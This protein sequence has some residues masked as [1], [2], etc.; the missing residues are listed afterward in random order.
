MRHRGLGRVW[1]AAGL[2]LLA[3]APAFAADG[4]ST[5]PKNEIVVFGGASILDATRR[6]DSTVGIPGW[7]AGP[8]SRTSR[9]G[10]RPRSGAA[11]S[12]GPAIPA[13]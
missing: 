13:T 6:Q 9:S 10:R 3:A 7:T 2:A 8:A 1:R 12:S 5:E 4:P 11:R